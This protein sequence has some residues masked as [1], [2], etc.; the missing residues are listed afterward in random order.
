MCS[1][2][3]QVAIMVLLNLL[4][5]IIGV[6]CAFS[7]FVPDFAPRDICTTVSVE[8]VATHY[9]IYISQ[10]FGT[11]TQLNI[12]GGIEID[13][14]VAPTIFVTNTI[15]AQTVTTTITSTIATTSLLPTSSGNSI[16]R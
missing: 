2:L 14:S 13:I 6:P 16:T 9:P 10:Y 5:F 8:V 7:I 15:S 3:Y 1:T 11:T 4:T 12:D